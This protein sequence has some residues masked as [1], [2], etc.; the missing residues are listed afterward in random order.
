VEGTQPYLHSPDT[1]FGEAIHNLARFTP[2]QMPGKQYQYSN[3]NYVLLGEIISRT[4]GHS[5]SEYIQKNI[6]DPLEMSHTTFADYHTLP[7]AATGNLIVFG[8]TVP[9][10]EPH[11]PIML[12]AGYLS[13]TAE[14]MAH[15]LVAFL[16][17]GNYNGKDILPNRGQGWYDISWYWHPGFPADV[18]YGFSGGHLSFSTNIQLFPLHR[19]GVVVLTNTRLDQ[20]IPSFTVNDI[21]FNIAHIALESPYQLPPNRRFYMGYVWLDGFLLFMVASILWQASKL[22]GWKIQY[23]TATGLK[24]IAAWGGI[25]FDLLICLAILVLPIVFESRWSI[26]LHFRPDFALPILLIGISLGALGIIKMAGSIKT[27]NEPYYPLRQ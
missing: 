22:R 24:R 27:F 26:L 11:L 5:Y 2:G 3:W 18:D 14:D 16:N 1:T 17:H 25:I 4:S 13:S 12:S 23:Q 10:D 7:D 6:L 8:A 9:Y 19:V 21:A 15:Y 20:I